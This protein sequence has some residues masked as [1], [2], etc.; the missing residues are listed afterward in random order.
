MSI[1]QRHNINMAGS[2]GKTILFAHG[3]GCDQVMWRFLVPSFQDGY[4]VVLFDHVGA[5]KSDLSCY[6][7]EKY[8][9][10]DGYADDV[11]DIIDS[12]GGTPVVFVGHSVSAMI[13]VLA[14]IKRPHVFDRLVLIGPSPCY[15]NN[16][17]Y[18]GGFSKIDIEG[19]LQT[20]DENHLGWSKAMAPVIMKNA[21]RPELASELAESFCRTDPEIARHFARVTFLSD[22]RSDLCRVTVPSLVLQCS[23]DSIAPEGVGDFV[24]RNL[25]NSALIK[26]Q[27][28]GHCPHM[29]GPVETIKSI[30]SYLAIGR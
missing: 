23:D 17:D 21:E 8:G 3:Y 12:V 25:A 4:R 10:L 20:L 1:S 15:I 16:G 14:A 24:H 13:G 9:T 26:L 27:A 28:T 7:R 30:K 2:G 19:L 5:G 11:L 22:N 6:S 18:A 29:S